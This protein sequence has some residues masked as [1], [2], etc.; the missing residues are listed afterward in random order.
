MSTA[1]TSSTSFAPATEDDWVCYTTDNGQP[2]YFNKVTRTTSWTKVLTP[3]PTI[4]L[5][6]KN[7]PGPGSLWKENK[8]PSGELYYYNKESKATTWD[9]PEDFYTMS[10][11]IETTPVVPKAVLANPSPRREEK[12]CVEISKKSIPQPVFTK[13]A[14]EDSNDGDQPEDN[15]KSRAAEKFKE[16]IKDKFEQNRFRI[17]D[18]WGKVMRHLQT[19][20]RYNIISR[21]N[22][23]KHIFNIWKAQYAKQLRV[24]LGKRFI[25]N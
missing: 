1:P 24:C 23:K 4:L 5:G 13:P 11:K 6:G 8:S 7:Q 19:D 21:V 15:V 10:G 18:N 17:D 20:V 9:R 25:I 14:Q 2:Y 12:P 22:E 3:Q 16:L